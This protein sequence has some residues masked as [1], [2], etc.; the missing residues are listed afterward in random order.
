MADIAAIKDKLSSELDEIQSN[1]DIGGHEQLQ[2]NKTRIDLDVGTYPH[3]MLRPPSIESELIDNHTTLRTYNFELDVVFKMENLEKNDIEKTAEAIMNHFDNISDDL[4]GN[5]DGGI[6][7]ASTAPQITS[8]KTGTN[9]AMIT[10]I[11]NVRATET[12][13]Y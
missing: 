6:E 7:V 4:E 10:V 2:F 11:L 1:G 8:D 13:N 3:V 12:L 5:A 9:Y